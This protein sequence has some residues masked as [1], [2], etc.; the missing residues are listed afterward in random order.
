MKAE[1]K[2]IELDH[3]NSIKELKQ[4]VDTW[5]REG[6][7]YW[8]R[9][10]SLYDLKALLVYITNLQKRKIT[11]KDVNKYFEENMCVSFDKFIENWDEQERWSDYYKKENEKLKNELL[12]KPDSEITLTTEDGKKLTIIQ[13]ERIDIQEKLN[14]SLEEIYKKYNDYKLRIDKANELIDNYDVFKEFS[15]PLMKRDVEQQIKSS[16]DYEF[17]ITFRNKLKNILNVGEK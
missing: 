10:F 3:F 15:F 6:E 11:K 2:E 7:M 17:K 8:E 12:S 1:I 16:I 4:N 14:K 9:W 5:I 13:S